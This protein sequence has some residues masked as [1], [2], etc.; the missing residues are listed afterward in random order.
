MNVLEIIVIAVIAWFAFRGFQ[1]GFVKKLAAMV[2]LVLSI[3]LVSVFLP[4]ITDYLKY[5]T[6]VYMVIENK[7]EEIVTKKLAEQFPDIYQNEIREAQN[8]GRIEQTE[9]IENLPLPQELT[10]MLL[11]Y[12]NSEGYSRLHVTG[13]QE[14]IVSFIASVILNVAAFLVSVLVVQLLLWAVIAALNLVASIPVIRFVNRL[15]GMGLGLLQ[16]L[17][18]IWIFFLIL[19]MFSGTDAGMFLL[20][21]VH[22]S[23]FLSEMYETN[24][25]LDIV[26]R[27][28]AILV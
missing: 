22:E 13:F 19:S 14:Y 15:A 28:A 5:E 23:E 9:I 2:S 20:S 25:F 16:V 1:K 18:L 11:D 8:P 24:V 21:L 27:A 26:L 4:Y 12:N 6:P 17:F 3:V 7:C 10:D